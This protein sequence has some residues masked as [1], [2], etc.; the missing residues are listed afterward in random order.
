MKWCISDLD[1]KADRTSF[2]YMLTCVL[3]I[4]VQIV[5]RFSLSSEFGML[6]D[7]LVHQNSLS[8]L[9][10][11]GGALFSVCQNIV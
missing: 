1:L 11:G 6:D 7:V 2:L 9:S 3:H 5:I 4:Y 8:G 10:S